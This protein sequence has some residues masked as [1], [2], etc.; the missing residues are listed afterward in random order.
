VVKA[1]WCEW[2]GSVPSTHRE[3]TKPPVIQVPEDPVCFSGL[4]E[5]TSHASETL[6]YMLANSHV[7]KIKIVYIYIHT[8]YIYIVS[9]RIGTALIFEHVC[10][11]QTLGDF[12]R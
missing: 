10:N 9:L 1:S 5:G 7:H 8:I 12:W 4:Q 3:L 6:T 2:S 11:C